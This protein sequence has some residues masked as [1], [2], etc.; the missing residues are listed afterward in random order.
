MRTLHHPIHHA[1]PA[2]VQPSPHPGAASQPGQ[3]P[4]SAH[5]HAQFH[6][7]R[8]GV[9]RQ[10]PRQPQ[11]QAQGLVRNRTAPQA[12]SAAE[13]ENAL[14]GAI[15]NAERGGSG[16]GEDRPEG[17]ERDLLRGAARRDDPADPQGVAAPPRHDDAHGDPDAAA[18]A[19][20]QRRL[21]GG[22]EVGGA[23]VVDDAR[24]LVAAM[25]ASGAGAL[26][27]R[28]AALR[29]SA[30]ADPA[31]RHHDAD[32]VQV[33]V[34]Q[35]RAASLQLL[36]SCLEQG[37]LLHADLLR[38]GLLAPSGDG[39]GL[40]PAERTGVALLDAGRAAGGGALLTR[41]GALPGQGRDG[42]KAGQ[43]LA[44]A[45][46]LLPDAVW[47]SKEARARLP[48]ELDLA[49]GEG[50]APANGEVRTERHLRASQ[51]NRHA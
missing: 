30:A 25:T 7:Q 33:W 35:R 15:A 11:P 47:P 4:P 29:R 46:R 17:L 41:I 12:R 13:P 22:A 21:G 43:M 40:A 19:Q 44:A 36:T 3:A 28:V 26:L 24:E 39:K 23:S 10:M 51:E 8:A 6:Q 1:A 42:R 38:N 2:L 37:A 5:S 20:M 9:L 16:A 49:A 18:L 45:L 14:L 50:V 27:D 32:G 34:A 48:H 31:M